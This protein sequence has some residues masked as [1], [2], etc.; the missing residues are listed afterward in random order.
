MNCKRA[1]VTV[2]ALLLG[3]SLLGGRA[4]ASPGEEKAILAEMSQESAEASIPPAA[5]GVGLVLLLALGAWRSRK[6]R[7]LDSAG[8]STGSEENQI[9]DPYTRLEGVRKQRRWF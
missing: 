2:F 9:G 8:Y 1:V 5:G 7:M 6:N 3:L 4:L